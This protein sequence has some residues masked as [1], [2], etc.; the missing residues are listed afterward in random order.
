VSSLLI[1]VVLMF[2]LGTHRPNWLAISRVPLFISAVTLRKAPRQ[3]AACVWALDS[4]GFSELSTHG[5]WRGND[6]MYAGEV[7]M[8]AEK[9]GGLQWAA[10][11]DHMCEPF[12][13]EKTGGTVR[14]HQMRTIESLVNLRAIAPWI[15]WAPVLQGWQPD[16]YES[17]A[18]AYREAGFDLS[19]EPI[20]GVGS[21]C[22]RQATSEG[23]AVFRRVATLG[24]RVHAFGVKADG[25]RR[26]GSL[27]AS[28]DSMAWSFVARRRQIRLDGCVGHKNCANCF[29]FAMQWRD[30]LVASLQTKE[31]A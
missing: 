25:L 16:D 2:F 24:L 9:I 19:R 17:H 18:Q 26:Y 5:K 14:D 29:R 21:V 7:N 27:L 1:V 31:A 12:I 20:V 15:P 3:K 28:A 4:G 8:W 13:L 22:R 10:I 23:E 11:R 30:S 6:N